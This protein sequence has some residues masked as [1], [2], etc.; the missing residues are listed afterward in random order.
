MF[1]TVA[2]AGSISEFDQFGLDE[3]YDN[4]LLLTPILEDLSSYL[5]FCA[6]G[7]TPTLAAKACQALNQG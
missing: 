1:I 4:T 5:P 6:A 7:W 3:M 2:L